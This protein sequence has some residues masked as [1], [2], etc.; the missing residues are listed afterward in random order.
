MQKT[1]FVSSSAQEKE[2]ADEFITHLGN[3]FEGDLLF[4]SA[5]SDLAAGAK[6]KDWIQEKLDAC[7]ASLFIM[8]PTYIQSL[9]SSAEFTAFWLSKRPIFVLL[10]GNATS[11]QL[12]RPMQDD[13]QATH[14]SDK[15]GLRRFMENLAKLCHRPRTP[16]QFVDLL[17][18]QCEEVYERILALRAE[19][20]GAV[21]PTLLVAE[22]STF[23]LRH[24]L[25]ETEWN[26]TLNEDRETLR[27]ECVRTEEIV[28]QS[29]ATD[30]LP[31]VVA[32][33]ANL[34]RFDPEADYKIEL[35]EYSYPKGRVSI[36]RNPVPIAPNGDFNFQL[37]FTPPLKHGSEVRVRYRFVLPALKAATSEK[38]RA[39]LQTSPTADLRSYEKFSMR[40]K[41]PA[42]KFVYAVNFDPTCIVEPGSPEASWRQSPI[43]KESAALIEGAYTCEYIEDEGWHLRLEREQPTVDTVYTFKWQLPHADDLL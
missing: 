29:G 4:S 10:V 40:L 6:W 17:S 24:E 30:F 23:P 43:A 12:F 26:M 28:C 2:L 19:K 35:L 41:W 3:A 16:Y 1:I 36:V 21:E 22:D 39:L 38:L 15:D 27:G 25:F 31:V 18:F 7:D 11:D 5:S 13:Y 8:T 34:V 9:W 42:K 32:Q 20:A 37:R 33:A 14:I